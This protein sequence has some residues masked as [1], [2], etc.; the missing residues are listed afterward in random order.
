MEARY[1]KDS[2]YTSVTTEDIPHMKK[3][4]ALNKIST[5]LNNITQPG[6]KNAHAR[7]VQTL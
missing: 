2:D 7:I 3:E 1:L 5:L 4:C 6:G